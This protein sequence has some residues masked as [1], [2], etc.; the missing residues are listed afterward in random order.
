MYIYLLHFN[1]LT[2]SLT[3]INKTILVNEMKHNLSLKLT[4]L[5]ISL[6]PV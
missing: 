6:I 2:T 3:I 1:H 5:F 4:L